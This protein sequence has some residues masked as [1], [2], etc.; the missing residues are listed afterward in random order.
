MF[1]SDVKIYIV[2]VGFKKVRKFYL[3]LLLIFCLNQKLEYFSNKKFSD[4]K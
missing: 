3:F 1:V 4:V 2:L